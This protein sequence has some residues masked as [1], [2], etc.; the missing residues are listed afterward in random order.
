MMHG[1]GLALCFTSV[2]TYIGDIIPER[3]LNE[4]IG[5]FGVTGLTGL[6]AGPFVAETVIEHAG[7]SMF[8]VVA[9]TIAIL[10]LLLHV[11]LPE[12]YTRVTRDFSPS[13]FS[14][15]YR[16]KTSL[17]AAVAIMFGFALAASGGFIAPFGQERDISL[18]SLYYIAYSS[19]AVLTR[20][21]GGKLADRI[22]EGRVIPF[23]LAIAGAGLLMLV[24][25]GGMST[26]ILSGLMSGCGHGFL[27]P[28]L[29]ALAIRGEPISVRGK[30][31]GVFTGGIDAGAFTGSVVLGYIGEWVGF[32]GLFLAAA[33]ALFMGLWL[34][35][36]FND[37]PH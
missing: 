12:S 27:F 31:T 7:F 30:M 10:G 37:I 2:F 34:Y 15:L 23:A 11:S 13:F 36:H 1:V 18:I 14:I 35:M 9:S 32:Q 24:F 8:F 17:L 29:N 19:S 26:L 3:R 5:M 20:L 21:A 28:S 25:L 33:L 6:A 16:K 4:G 22:G